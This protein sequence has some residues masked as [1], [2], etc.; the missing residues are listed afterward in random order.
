VLTAIPSATPGEICCHFGNFRLD[1]LIEHFLQF[2]VLPP[3]LRHMMIGENSSR[4]GDEKP[5][6]ED[7]EVYLGTN[8]CEGEEWI[9]ALIGRRLAAGCQPGIAQFQSAIVLTKSQHDMDKADTGL[10]GLD[11]SLS[12]LAFGL[13]LLEA[14]FHCDELFLQCGSVFCSL[15]I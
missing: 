10:I 1:T 8:P 14:A 15:A 2:V 13:N 11:D 5:S 3:R 6:A 4:V 12:K 7:I 9:F